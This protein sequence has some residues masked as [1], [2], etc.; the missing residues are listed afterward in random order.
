MFSLS[1]QITRLGTKVCCLYQNGLF[2]L[3]SNVISQASSLSRNA[4]QDFY[5]L[6][7]VTPLAELCVWL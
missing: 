6:T 1:I 4:D 7:D 2:M 5:G 3:N